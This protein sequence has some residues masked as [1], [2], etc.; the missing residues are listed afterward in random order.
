VKTESVLP[1]SSLIICSRNRPKLLFET[2]ESV[3]CGDDLP[4][5]IV[6]VDQSAAPHPQLAQ[7]KTARPCEIRY[8]HSKTV[9]VGAG[10]NL[11]IASARKDVLFFIDD[12]MF[13]ASHW[14]KNLLLGVIQ[15]GR[16][17]VVTGQVLPAE[18]EVPGGLA[19]STKADQEPAVYQGR[20]SKDVLFSGNMGAYRAIFDEVGTFDE[21]LGPG[22]AFPAAEDNDLGFRLL[23]L[24]YR[25]CYLP[26][27]IVYHRAWRSKRENLSLEWRYGVGRGAYY[28]KH[29]RWRDAYMLF[30]LARDIKSNLMEFAGYF[31]RTGRFSFD[32]LFLIFGLF[33]GAIRWGITQMGKSSPRWKQ[34]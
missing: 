25:I 7:M 26:D 30:R 21:R 11:G 19:P 5:E 34:A 3:L 2:V 32:Y 22:T 6:I 24:G 27:A 18:P 31:R 20:I 33:Y 4:N 15:A 16:R 14:F 13:V 10:R 28:A 17:A 23:E 1:Q 29:L 12:D 8:I 9:G